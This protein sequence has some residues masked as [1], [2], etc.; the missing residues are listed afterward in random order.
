MQTPIKDAVPIVS[1]EDVGLYFRQRTGL[2]K[3]RDFWALKKVSLNLYHGETLGVVG[4]NGAGKTSLLKVIAGVISPNR[5]CI[6]NNGYRASLLSLQLGFV[7][8][9]S[10]RD[11]VVLSGLLLGLTR[12]QVLS[13]MK[14]IVEFAEI[15]EFIDQPIKTFSAGMKARLGFSIAIQAAPDILLID[16]IL[17]VGDADF[18]TKSSAALRDLIRSDKTVVIVSHQPETIRSLCHRA[19]WIEDRKSQIEGE[20]EEVL[21]AYRLY[22]KNLH[23]K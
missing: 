20:V 23:T 1:L 11:N 9:L 12:Q 10:G 6:I 13:K 16:E 2:L 5:G 18:R 14:H 22:L 15:E 19:V 21:D 4:R 8:N 17:G 7:P 3:H